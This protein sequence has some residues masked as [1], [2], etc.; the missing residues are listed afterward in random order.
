MRGSALRLL[1]HWG[2]I[3]VVDSPNIHLSLSSNQ[4]AAHHETSKSE[5]GRGEDESDSTNDESEGRGDE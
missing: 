4:S 5:C 1:I 3:A 2:V